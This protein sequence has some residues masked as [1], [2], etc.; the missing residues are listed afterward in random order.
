LLAILSQQAP[1][2]RRAACRTRGT[3][4]LRMGPRNTGRDSRPPG[5]HLAGTARLL[6]DGQLPPGQDAFHLYH[7]TYTTRGSD[8]YH[9]TSCHYPPPRCHPISLDVEV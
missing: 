5:R 2:T 3:D 4:A 1:L 8:I 7:P 6:G 9:T